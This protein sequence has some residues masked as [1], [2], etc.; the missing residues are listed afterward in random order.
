M[1]YEKQL[2]AMRIS[3]KHCIRLAMEWNTLDKNKHKL[4][5]KWTNQI[6]SAKTVN[7]QKW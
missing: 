4:A 2:E 1:Q 6:I 3:E 5:E 7:K